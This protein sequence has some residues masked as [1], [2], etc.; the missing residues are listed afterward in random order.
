MRSEM[1]EDGRTY[2]MQSDSGVVRLM[3]FGA[4]GIIA[5]EESTAWARKRE[6]ATA[7]TL[8]DCVVKAARYTGGARIG[9][10]RD[11][12]P[13]FEEIRKLTEDPKSRREMIEQK[14]S[15][16]RRNIIGVEMAH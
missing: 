6:Y 11:R 7:K 14:I 9:I 4:F 8:G 13:Y 5:Y 3:V 10:L 15:I 16:R 2:P 12:R 1:V